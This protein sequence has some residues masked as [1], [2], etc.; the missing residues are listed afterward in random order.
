M[1]KLLIF[2]LLGLITMTNNFIYSHVSPPSI[3]MT[4]KIEK[5]VGQTLAKK[6]NM[7]FCGAGGG[8][9][10]G[11]VDMLALSFDLERQFTIEEARAILIDCVNTYVN[12]VNADKELKPYLKNSPFT[13]ENIKISIFFKSPLSDDFYD[14]Y[15]RVA[16]TSHGDLIYRT[17]EKGKEF[18]YKSEII[19][20]YEDAVKILNE[21]KNSSK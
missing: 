4:E 8:M 16:C 17:K 3:A 6:Y 5:Q 11:I 1:K 7:K 9:P 20:S 21:N 2:I 10:D 12:A 14:P 19:E 13:P 15:L 18:G